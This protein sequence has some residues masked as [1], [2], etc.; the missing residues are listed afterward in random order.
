MSNFFSVPPIKQPE[1]PVAKLMVLVSSLV[2]FVVLCM[3]VGFFCREIMLEVF[4]PEEIDGVLLPGGDVMKMWMMGIRFDLQMGSWFLLPMIMY[5]A[6]TFMF[7]TLWKWVNHGLTALVFASSLGIIGLMIINFHYYFTTAQPLHWQAIDTFLANPDWGFI[8]DNYSV[9]W[10]S[11]FALLF[12]GIMAGVWK[13]FAFV[14]GNWEMWEKFSVWHMVGV[15]V[16][17]TY[18]F[19]MFAQNGLASSALTAKDARVST[20]E[21]INHLV[22]SAPS[23]LYYDRIQGK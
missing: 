19:M 16:F 20:V 11:F 18:V 2:I 5:C 14:I 21:P 23:I 22:M 15:P 4:V 9:I 8:W 3:A 6:L 10:S 17:I 7:T 12:A 13:R 1:N